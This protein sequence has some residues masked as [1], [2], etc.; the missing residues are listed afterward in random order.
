MCNQ[1]AKTIVRVAEEWGAENLQI[2]HGG[3]HPKLVGT[4]KDAGFFMVIPGTASDH[5]SEMNCISTLRRVL[6]IAR[7]EKAD[8]SQRDRRYRSRKTMKPDAL[9]RTSPCA[10]APIDK[11]YAPLAALRD[12]LVFGSAQP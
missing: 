7:I 8:C 5:R 4:F 1:I 6:G 2:V 10:A 3:K 11:F 12:K 9:L